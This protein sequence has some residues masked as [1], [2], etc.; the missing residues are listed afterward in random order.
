MSSCK[1]LQSSLTALS[2]C[3]GT[4]NVL[5]NFPPNT[6]VNAL[7]FVG[8]LTVLVTTVRFFFPTAIHPASSS[9]GGGA[10]DVFSTMRGAEAGL[11]E[12][13]WES[14]W[15]SSSSVS[16]KKPKNSSASSWC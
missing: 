6:L 12:R 4:L 11:G 16:R 15:S 10:V 13:D 1:A 8:P 9:E 7:S 2:F 14:A 5:I 3:P